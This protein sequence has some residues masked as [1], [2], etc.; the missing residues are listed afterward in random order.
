MTVFLSNLF[1]QFEAIT[2]KLTFKKKISW[3]G[4]A[5]VVQHL[6]SLQCLAC[7]FNPQHW[8]N[9]TFLLAFK[10]IGNSV[11]QKIFSVNLNFLSL[12]TSSKNLH[13]KLRTLFLKT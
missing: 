3:A 4:V 1:T 5:Q 7:V 10:D 11:S 13:S 2:Q 8:K 6:S 9:K 12:Q